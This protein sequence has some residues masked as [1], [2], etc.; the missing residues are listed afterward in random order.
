MHM[1]TRHRLTLILIHILLHVRLIS[2]RRP[3]QEGRARGP[4]TDTDCERRFY[5]LPPLFPFFVYYNSTVIISFS[6]CSCV[7][8]F[9]S[10]FS[11]QV[12][13]FSAVRFSICDT[14]VLSNRRSFKNQVPGCQLASSSWTL[15]RRC[16]RAVLYDKIRAREGLYAPLL[17]Y[18][19]G[20][21]HS[22]A[23]N[24]APKPDQC[25]R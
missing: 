11:L 20:A 17:P 3:W 23:R 15:Q 1:H 4:Y 10:F 2:P 8:G 19:G 14:P 9:S 6:V 22:V 25:S 7:C 21:G 5:Y 12:L 16:R 18:N 13:S 24:L